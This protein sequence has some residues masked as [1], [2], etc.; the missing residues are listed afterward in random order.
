MRF[1]KD[2]QRILGFRQDRPTAQSKIRQHQIMVGHHNIGIV[3]IFTGIKEGTAVKVGAVAIGALAMIGGYL[4]PDFIRNLFRPVVSVAV[5]LPG[6]IGAEHFFKY[7]PA[8]RF[9][10]H[11]LIQQEQG[12]GIAVT[13]ALIVQA[14]FQP[15]HTQIPAAAFGE[16][17]VEVQLAVLAQVWQVFQDNLVLKRHGCRRNNQCFTERL[18]NRNGRNQIRKCFTGTCARLHHTGGGR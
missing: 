9:V 10:I 7:R 15:G 5:P 16:C 17:P 18:G 6:T 4:A 11:R 1:V 12:H 14:G 8:A 2:K 13:V 3:Q